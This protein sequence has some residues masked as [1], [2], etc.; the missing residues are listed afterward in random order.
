MSAENNE[1]LLWCTTKMGMSLENEYT[2]KKQWS[3]IR[4]DTDVKSE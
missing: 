1:A 2:T 3:H 4:T